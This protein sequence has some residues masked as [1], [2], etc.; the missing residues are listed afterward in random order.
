MRGRARWLSLAISSVFLVAVMTP[1]A[2]RA[3]AVQFSDD[4]QKI[5]NLLPPGFS[6]GGCVTA[7]DP[8]APLDATASLQCA[9]NGGSKGP[10]TGRFTLWRD[11]ETMSG[12]FR[13]QT[14]GNPWFTP[15]PCPG[16]GGSTGSWSYNT[17]PD[18]A[19]GEVLCG[20]YQGAPNV[21]WTR[22]AQ[23]L[24]LDVNG[25]PD[26]ESLFQWWSASGNPDGGLTPGIMLA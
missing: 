7:T 25:G 12:D 14:G 22:N 15:V 21:E 20:S 8:P 2:P 18:Q 1:L 26:I 19:S 23:L 6:A 16:V 5:V 24:T 3:G 11:V 17:T 10:T 9:A 4:E 13:S